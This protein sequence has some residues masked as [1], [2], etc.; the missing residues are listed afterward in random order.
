MVSVIAGVSLSVCFTAGKGFFLFFISCEYKLPQPIVRKNDI[1]TI[2]NKFVCKG[3]NAIF[4]K[5]WLVF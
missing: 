3:L 1:K 5:L 2:L 4:V